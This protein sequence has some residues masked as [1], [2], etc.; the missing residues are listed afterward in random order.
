MTRRSAYLALLSVVLLPVLAFSFGG[1]AVITVEDLPDY[2]VAG[3][4]LT[5]SFMVRQHGM[6]VL[7][8]LRPSVTAKAG[9]AEVAANATGLISGRYAA[10]GKTAALRVR[11]GD[12]VVG[13]AP[14]SGATA[15]P[16]EDRAL[17]GTP[18]CGPPTPPSA[19]N[20]F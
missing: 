4:P 11:A 14:A 8:S 2:A 19:Q 16:R 10:T 3:K 6:T 17:G 1:W 20:R 15:R 12:H 9:E 18:R 7:T 5:L 13:S